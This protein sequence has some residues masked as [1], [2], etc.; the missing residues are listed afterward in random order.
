M[1]STIAT[2]KFVFLQYN[3]SG[4][5]I[6]TKKISFRMSHVLK[7]LFYQSTQM[8]CNIPS[9]TV[10]WSNEP[11]FY[12]IEIFIEI[13]IKRKAFFKNSEPISSNENWIDKLQ[14]IF[15]LHKSF[16]INDGK[17]WM[18]TII[19][20]FIYFFSSGAFW[21]GKKQTLFK[22]HIIW[23]AIWFY[24]NFTL[25]C[26]THMSTWAGRLLAK[27]LGHIADICMEP[28]SEW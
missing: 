6:S 21:N 13:S 19:R 17:W 27:H 3:C 10:R 9:Q 1:K 28:L 23:H 7:S 15:L 16:L 14:M 8:L 12:S 22:F 4:H 24:M 20:W 5:E 25:K 11:L 18:Y 2:Q 26:L